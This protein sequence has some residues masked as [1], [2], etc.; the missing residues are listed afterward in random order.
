MHAYTAAHRKLPLGSIVRVMNWKNGK[1]VQLRI[2]DRG[3][4]Y[5]WPNVGPLLCRRSRAWH[6]RS[7][8][9]AWPH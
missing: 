7:R 9:G 5:S 2:T 6:G 1:S 3:A 8:H 4:L